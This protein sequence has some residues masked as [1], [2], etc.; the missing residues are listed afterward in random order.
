MAT[1][2][3]M[4]KAMVSGIPIHVAQEIKRLLDDLTK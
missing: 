3:D 1:N 4:Q 2:Y